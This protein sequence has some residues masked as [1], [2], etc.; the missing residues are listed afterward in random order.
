MIK[1]GDFIEIEY[2]GKAKEDNFVFDTTSTEAAKEAN[3]FSEKGI[4]GPVVIV[5]GQND[6]LKG[7]DEELEGKEPGK[8]YT[9]ELQPESGFGKKDV[10]LIQLVPARK[11]KEQNINP[12]PGLQINVD[13]AVGTVRTAT[14]GRILVDFNH[15]LSGRELVYELKINKVITDK[16]EKTKSILKLHLNLKNEDITIENDVVK[17]P[18]KP[19]FTKEVQ[20]N[21][22]KKLK[23]LV[24]HD[25][26]IE[27]V[28]PVKDTKK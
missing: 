22:I 21:I 5:V 4:Y 10:S 1:K 9:V 20:D 18:A 6:V 19:Q 3:I 13:G 14:G 24:S 11:F 28:T 25:V 27:F 17:I 15:P 23:E 7:L 2:T 8:S 16:N 12:M 26:K